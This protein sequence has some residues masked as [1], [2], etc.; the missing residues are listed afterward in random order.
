MSLE[1]AICVIIIGLGTRERKYILEHLVDQR[2]VSVEPHY[3][4]LALLHDEVV[5]VPPHHH[6]LQLGALEVIIPTRGSLLGSAASSAAASLSLVL[7]HLQL[8]SL[9]YHG[10]YD[11]P[12]PVEIFLK[13]NDGESPLCTLCAREIFQSF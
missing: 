13:L 7:A 9:S 4:L 5:H 2:N 3:V 12:D 10:L 8:S 1:L 6:L 11:G